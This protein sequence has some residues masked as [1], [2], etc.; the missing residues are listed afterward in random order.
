VAWPDARVDR[1]LRAFI[2]QTSA[3][4]WPIFEEFQTAGRSDLY[5]QVRLLGG[6]KRWA[7]KLGL[8]Y[9]PRVPRMNRWDVDRIRAA[10]APFLT[11]VDHWPTV[12]A[13]RAAGLDTARMAMSEHGGPSRWAAEFNLALG[14]SLPS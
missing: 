5:V 9:V 12:A 11:A 6:D 14:H 1:E 3:Q 2:I 4:R 8:P 7:G 10:V 13:F